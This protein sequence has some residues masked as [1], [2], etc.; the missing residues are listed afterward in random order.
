MDPAVL[1]YLQSQQ[2][3]Q[4]PVQPQ[5][6]QSQGM[7]PQQGGAQPL[8][9][10]F[11]VGI[12]NAIESARQSLG[13]TQ[14]QQD[15]ALR[16]SVLTF[17]NNMSQQPR[18][19]GF[20][21]NFASVGR[22]MSPAISM[23]DQEEEAAFIQN[24][25][26]ANQI[27]KYQQGDQ[28]RQAAE[29]QRNWQRGHAEAQLAEQTR[30]HNLMHNFRTEREANKIGANSDQNGLVGGK[31]PAFASKTERSDY[32]KTYK[33]SS[34]VVKETNSI[35]QKYDDFETNHPNS[36]ALLPYIGKG[37][38]KAKGL[39]SA[40]SNDPALHDEVKSIAQ[41]NHLKGSVISDYETAK[42]K[43]VLTAGLV[44]IFEER[45]VVPTQKDSLLTIKSKM[46]QMNEIAKE[47]ALSSKYSLQYNAHI[48]PMDLPDFL[49]TSEQ[50]G[51][52]NSQ[53]QDE[54]Q[55]PNQGA[56]LMQDANGDQY[57]IP[58]E[59]VEGAM[60]EGLE[61]VGQ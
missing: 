16:S 59:E 32:A 1:N 57:N 11:N 50:K 47:L 23:H 3:N 33:S 10:P 46:E 55:M 38:S 31:Y 41:I 25:A 30:G 36:Y 28:D 18:E 2:N 14:K 20:L 42:R 21:N 48:T 39:M 58:A 35:L 12:S 40:F 26:L 52:Q 27:L 49:G 53:V 51:S 15:K 22:A 34:N 5:G 61:L 9:N 7:V 37:V 54:S 29:E 60:N 56:V 24:N 44:K 17:A 8:S 45:D 6:M 43:G 4:Q 13:M 19:R